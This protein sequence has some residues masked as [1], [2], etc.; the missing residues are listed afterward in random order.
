MVSDTFHRD[1]HLFFSFAFGIGDP[2]AREI[3][4]GAVSLRV[5][6]KG[7]KR[8]FALNAAPAR[9]YCGA[10]NKKGG[11]ALFMC[12][13]LRLGFPVGQ[14]VQRPDRPTCFL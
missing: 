8:A 4:R 7:L 9:I 12:D 1:G 2:Y 6:D 3:T 5:S 10:Y 11:L 13:D 14:N